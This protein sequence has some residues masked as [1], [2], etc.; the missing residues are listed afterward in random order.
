M[1]VNIID[2]VKN[3]LSPSVVSQTATQLGES[4]S[5]VSKAISALLPVL[6]GG[7][8]DKA[9]STPGLLDQLKGLASSGILSSLGSGASGNNS[10]VSGILSSVFGDKLSGIISSVSSFAGIKES[11]A[12]SV[13]G[14][15]SEATLGTI[16]KYAA[17]NNLDEA[18]FSSLLSGQKSWITSLIPAGLSLGSLGLGGIFSGLGDKAEEVKEAVSEKIEDIKNVFTG[19]DEEKITRSGNTFTPPPPAGNNGGGGSV[20][21]WLLPLILLGLVCW[22]IWKQCK[23]KENSSTTMVTTSTS[24]SPA[25]SD[26]TNTTTTT[27]TK[28]TT[29]IDVKGVS[30][31][32]FKGG[33][34]ESMVNFLN[35]GKY[36]TTDDETLKT[37]W[38][39]FDNVNFVIG[40]ADQLEAG[41]EGQIQNIATILKAFP[42]AKIKIGGYT[43]KTG[44]EANNLKLS[45]DRANYIKAEL[46]KLGV[47]NQILEAKGYG[48]EHA[49]VAATASNEE[50]AVD[51]KMAIRFAK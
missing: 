20:W 15:T 16:G 4:E 41:S 9:T 10:I 42:D 49:T 45:Q 50:R 7:V 48:S 6:V 12:Q 35:S 43:D 40:K 34:E 3:Y 39:N 31:K 23:A 46:T 38:Y 21:K 13:L 11:S 37:T 19:D 22:F 30:L 17:D 36:A 24:T 25:G 18:G 2:L 5:G 32:G 44:N 27:T 28:E 51:R 1:S 33:M 8:A 26:S 14:L 47:G 29:T